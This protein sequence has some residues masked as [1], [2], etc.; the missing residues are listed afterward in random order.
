MVSAEPV[1]LAADRGAGAA[2]SPSAT[3]APAPT[4]CGWPS[5]A[6]HATTETRSSPRRAGPWPHDAAAA[7]EAAWADHRPGAGVPAPPGRRR[8]PRG[9]SG[10]AAPATDW[11]ALVAHAVAADARR[12]VAGRW[13]CVPDG[14][15][16]ARVDARA[17]RRCSAPASTSCSPPTPVPARRYRDFLAVAAARR[18]VVVGTRA[19]A[20][21]PVRDLGLVVIWDDGDDLHAEPRAPYPHAREML[22]L[23]AEREGA[24]RAGRW[25]RAH[26]RGRVPAS[27]PAGRTSSAADR[28]EVR[29]RVTVA[30]AG[31]DEPR[32]PG[33]STARGRA[34]ARARCTARSATRWS[35]GP[36][37]VQTPRRGY[38]TALAC[39]R[40]R[41]PARCRACPGPLALTG[42]A[43]PAGLP[44]VRHRRRG[45]G[46]R[47]VRPP[48]AAGAGAGRCPHRRGAGPRASRAPGSAP[49]PAA[50]GA[51]DGRRRAAG[52]GGHPGRR[53]GRRRAA[54]PPS[55]CSTPGCCSRRTDLRAGEEAL[56]RWANA[57]GA[58]P[59][60]AGGWSRSATRRT[61]PL[62]A[63]VRWD[64]AGFAARET[65]ER[66]RGAPAAGL[67]A[68]HH[69]RRARGGRRRAHPARRAGRRRAARPG[70]PSADGESRA[71]R[72]GAAGRRA[73]TLSRALGELQ[74]VRSAPQ[75]RRR[76]GSRSIRRRSDLR[77]LH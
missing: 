8:Q 64:P 10:R 69:H 16:V 42:P 72:P 61:P 19:A 33:T 29:R 71:G 30:V 2:R 40:C 57:A 24:G 50:T 46:L 27:A 11:P 47:R 22:L 53:A 41:T 73:P 44:L 35:T 58:G 48:R 49:A 20:F 28:A 7:G 12:R 3:P 68:G 51:G 43:T 62:Q 59:R 34:D 26:R 39:E 36:V 76:C 18:R 5:R 15:D 1:L 13:S 37:L 6:R 38:V 65:A 75:A 54:T 23:R 55:C 17:D 14:K 74:R 70:R 77:A 56:R 67:P 32:W 4:C 9:R 45:L 63:L 52:R 25:L 60:R 21:A 31:A 66:R